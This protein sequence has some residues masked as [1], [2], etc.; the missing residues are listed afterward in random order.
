MGS[1]A[2]KYF[3][4]NSHIAQYLVRMDSRHVIEHTIN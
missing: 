2:F 4:V 1:S 3:I